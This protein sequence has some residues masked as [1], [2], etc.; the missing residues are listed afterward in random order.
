MSSHL[1]LALIAITV[2]LPALAQ[3]VYRCG[4][5]Y[6]QVPCNAEAK[7][8]PITSAAAPDQPKAQ[9]GAGLCAAH[10]PALLRF[11][12]PPSTRINS[13]KK[14]PAELIQYAGQPIV[15]RQYV[16]SIN[17][18]N[19]SGAYDGERPYVCFLSED[20]QRILKI[21]ALLTPS[22]ERMIVAAQARSAANAESVRAAAGGN[23]GK[24]HAETMAETQRIIES[25]QKMIDSDNELIR[26]LTGPTGSTRRYVVTN[27][28]VKG[29]K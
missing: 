11:P 15:A 13:V 28:P 27:P 1:S 8:V 25:T 29:S 18:K 7:P 17:A 10:A 12:D 16:M 9:Y 24:S 22:E 23:R 26:R 4:N 19:R 5:T 21:E 3:P 2:A 20:E 14:A 6:S